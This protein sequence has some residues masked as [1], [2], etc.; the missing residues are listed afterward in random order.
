[1]K[2]RRKCKVCNQSFKPMADKQWKIVK[3][4]HETMSKKHK[5]YKKLKLSKH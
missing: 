1:M 2:I 5:D 3:Y 4:E